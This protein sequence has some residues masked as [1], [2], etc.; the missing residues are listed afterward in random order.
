MVQSQPTSTPKTMGL[1]LGVQGPEAGLGDQ[2][3]VRTHLGHSW[4]DHSSSPSGG[5][6]Q[7]WVPQILDSSSPGWYK[8]RGSWLRPR[9][10][11]LL[12]PALGICMDLA[13]LT[14]PATHTLLY[15]NQR[16]GAKVGSCSLSQQADPESFSPAQDTQRAC[17]FVHTHAQKTHLCLLLLIYSLWAGLSLYCGSW[18]FSSVES[19]CYSLAEVLRLLSSQSLGPRHVGFSSGSMKP[20]S[21]QLVDSRF[22][23]CGAQAQW[24]RSTLDLPGPGTKPQSLHRQEDFFLLH[25][26]ASFPFFFFP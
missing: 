19:G 8:D 16:M 6:P 3:Q 20:Q 18:A 9:R 23:C 14:H 10:R 2:A 13:V 7:W 24:L 5:T 4:E 15:S 12:F 26:E 25:H 21:L 1:T 17:T 22:S 11:W